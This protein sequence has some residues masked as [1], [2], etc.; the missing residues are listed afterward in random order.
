MENSK[1]IWNEL[2]A[3]SPVIA[4]IEKVN[5]FTVPAG[6]FES[7]GATVLISIKEEE[8]DILGSIKAPAS[9]Q[10]PEGYFE[11][12]A[13]NILNKIKVN[14]SAATELN[15]LSPLLAGIENK[16]VFTVPQGYFESLAGNVLHTINAADDAVAELNTLS[17]TLQGLQTKNVF[18]VPQGYFESLSATILAKV[19][20][21]QAK[22]VTMQRRSTNTILKYAIAAVF[23]GVMALGVYKFTNNKGGSGE[24]APLTAANLKGLEI[25]KKNTFEQEFAKVSNE[26]IASFL[27]KDGVDVEAAV[28]VSQMQDKLDNEETLNT[29]KTESNEIDDLFNQLDNNTQTN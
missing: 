28:A 26:D 2:K 27:A 24:V 12:L 13:G 3:L 23:T 16:N 7:L 9:M 1:D 4:G 18:T 6:Y 29:D 17:P 21:Q 11:S 20:P 14:D 8:G 10:V 19:Q 5:V 22:V 15:E 25:A